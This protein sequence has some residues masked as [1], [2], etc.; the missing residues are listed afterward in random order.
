MTMAPVVR[1]QVALPATSTSSEVIEVKH[2]AFIYGV[3]T[4]VRR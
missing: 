3:T 1:V 4:E 2:W